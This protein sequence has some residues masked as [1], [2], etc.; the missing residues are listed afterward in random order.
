MQQNH[1]LLVGC[2]IF[3]DRLH[4]FVD[5]MEYHFCTCELCMI[6]TQFRQ[7]MPMDHRC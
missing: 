3:P 1:V 2:S 6:W 7:Q 5:D 4:F